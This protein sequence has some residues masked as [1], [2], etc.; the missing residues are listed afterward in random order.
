[1]RAS[2]SCLHCEFYFNFKI[3]IQKSVAFLYTNNEL[4]EREIK[5][6]IP[7]TT[8]SKR[9]KYLRINLTKEVKDLYSENYK[10]LMKEIEDDTNRKIYHV[11]GLKESILFKW[12]YYPRQSADSTQ[13]LSNYQWHFSHNKNK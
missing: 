3:N 9:I 13:S 7:F 12:P 8:A 10:A 5:E 2:V 11:L 4:L 6:T 1:M